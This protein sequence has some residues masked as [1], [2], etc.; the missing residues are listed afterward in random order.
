MA[1][2]YISHS[3]HEMVLLVHDLVDLAPPQWQK[4]WSNYDG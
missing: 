4:S 3:D 1:D 2:E